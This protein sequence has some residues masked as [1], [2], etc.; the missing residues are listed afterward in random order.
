ME[1]AVA[2]AARARGKAAAW[3]T[4]DTK[5]LVRLRVNDDA[6]QGAARTRDLIDAQSDMGGLDMGQRY[7]AG[8]V[9][10]GAVAGF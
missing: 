8:R 9:G 3:I 1:A 7:R 2:D 4:V 6:S 10:L 5:V